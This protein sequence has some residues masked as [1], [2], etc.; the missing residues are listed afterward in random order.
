MKRYKKSSANYKVSANYKH[1]VKL[2]KEGKKVVCF[3]TYD[4]SC[5][6][7]K[8]M[9][10]TDVC[11]AQYDDRSKYEEYH[12]FNVVCRGTEFFGVS[13]YQT[14]LS[15]AQ[16]LNLEQLFVK[17]CKRYKLKYIEPTL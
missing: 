6:D 8:P 3:V 4:F 15:Y 10:V 13:K 7:N 9:Y 14:K 16:G 1:L 11:M 2:L 5:G 17:M 12:G